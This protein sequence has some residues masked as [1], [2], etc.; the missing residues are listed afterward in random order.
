MLLLVLLIG[1]K[2]TVEHNLL[3]LSL[4]LLRCVALGA[5][6]VE[7][8][9]IRRGITICLSER[10]TASE[11]R[12]AMGLKGRLTI[13]RWRVSPMML[14]GRLRL[15]SRS[16]LASSFPLPPRRY[17]PSLWYCIRHRASHAPSASPQRGIRVSR[18]PLRVWRGDSRAMQPITHPALCCISPLSLSLSCSLPLCS[19]SLCLS[20][21][22]A[23]SR[24]RP[25]SRPASQR[26]LAAL[27]RVVRS[28]KCASSSSTTRT[29]ASS[30]TSRAR[31]ARETS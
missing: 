1:R 25:S 13:V 11:Q 31:S 14:F 22:L 17:H 23:P 10:R 28:R 19:P 6:L 30:A 18:C 29:A 24:K 20:P 8:L 26:S 3:S 16:S 2:G 9:S 21:S 5:M 7:Q 15:S 12:R 4:S 27:A